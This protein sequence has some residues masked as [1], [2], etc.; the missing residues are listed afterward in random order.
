MSYIALR[1]YLP[2]GIVLVRLEGSTT[3]EQLVQRIVTEVSRSPL[4]RSHDHDA[5]PQDAGREEG[6]ANGLRRNEQW[7]FRRLR[8]LKV[9]LVLDHIDELQTSQDSL[10][11]RVFLR[12]LFDQTTQ[13]VKVLVTSSRSLDLQTLPGIGVAETIV[14]V[15]PLTLRNTVRLFARLCPHL[16]T[17]KER[18]RFL[19]TLVIPDQ[20][21]VTVTSRYT[22]LQP[23][24]PII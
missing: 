7:L 17:A 12:Q 1:R 10:D 23:S 24:F 5:A 22:P 15:G 3:L 9:L 13:N 6:G 4:L 21:D 18:R 19:E 14:A 11:L 2:D 16:H 20:A 8:H